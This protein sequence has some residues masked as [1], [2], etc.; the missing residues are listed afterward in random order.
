M[1]QSA[2]KWMG[3]LRL[4]AKDFNYREIDRQLK[5]QFIHRLNDTDMLAEIIMELTKVKENTEVTSGN[6]VC[7]VK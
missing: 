5:K 3:R 6:V 4:A 7:Y 1:K 2:E